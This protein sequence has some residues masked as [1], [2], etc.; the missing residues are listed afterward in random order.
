[1]K[2]LEVSESVLRVTQCSV[3]W[4]SCAR[5]CPSPSPFPAYMFVF[6]LTTMTLLDDPE[7]TRHDPRFSACIHYTLCCI[8]TAPK[9]ATHTLQAPV[10]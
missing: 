1:M 4:L 10:L 6:T 2:A 5:P 9:P 8:T 3:L 7:M